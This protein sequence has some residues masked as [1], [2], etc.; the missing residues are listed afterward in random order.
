MCLS[1][2][3]AQSVGPN[4]DPKVWSRA[5]VQRV[6]PKLRSQ[7]LAQ[8]LG[9]KVLAQCFGPKLWSNAMFHS[10]S[11]ALAQR[12]GPKRCVGSAE[13]PSTCVRLPRHVRHICIVRRGEHHIAWSPLA[14][15]LRKAGLANLDGLTNEYSASHRPLRRLS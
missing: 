8:S 10:L 3:L 15:A 9:P 14:G 5:V 2:A 6:G 13:N 7:S 12:L 1:K 11:N 4:V